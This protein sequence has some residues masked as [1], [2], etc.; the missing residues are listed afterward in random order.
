MGT[1]LSA[2]TLKTAT[3]LGPA[4]VAAI[5]PFPA[6]APGEFDNFCFDFTMDVGATSITSTIWIAALIPAIQPPATR[7]HRLG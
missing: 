1:N 6:L 7:T 4:P 2:A 3:T 5:A